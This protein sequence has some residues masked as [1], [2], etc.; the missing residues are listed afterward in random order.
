MD[1]SFWGYS[2]MFMNSFLNKMEYWIIVLEQLNKD[3]VQLKKIY[4]I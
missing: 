2:K 1:K 4:T 3:F